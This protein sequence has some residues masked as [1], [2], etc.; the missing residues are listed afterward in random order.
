MRSNCYPPERT[1]MSTFEGVDEE[2][3]QHS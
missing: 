2:L 3:R 1:C